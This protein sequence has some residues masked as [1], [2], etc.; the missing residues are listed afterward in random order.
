MTSFGLY[1]LQCLSELPLWLF[2]VDSQD[3]YGDDMDIKSLQ[4]DTCGPTD[5][6]EPVSDFAEGILSGV[7]HHGTCL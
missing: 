6:F 4:G 5:A 3:R 7:K 2:K 1:F